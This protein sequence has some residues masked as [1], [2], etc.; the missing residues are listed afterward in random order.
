[1]CPVQWVPPQSRTRILPWVSLEKQQLL[2]FLTNPDTHAQ[3]LLHR[4]DAAGRS[5]PCLGDGACRYHDKEPFP[6]AYAAVVYLNRERECWEQA[7][8]GLGDP[9]HVAACKDHTGGEV[10]VRRKDAKN[11]RSS[12]IVSS[13]RMRPDFRPTLDL[14][15][16]FDVRPYI[17][18]RWGLFREAE[19]IGCDL[20]LPNPDYVPPA[21]EDTNSQPEQG[22]AR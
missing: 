20:H 15:Q 14:M 10:I 9:G 2:Y 17:L 16:P 1:M 21:D 5:F 13:G 19:L 22:K 8:L 12:I 3:L 7:I 4:I 6:Y 11:K 18:R